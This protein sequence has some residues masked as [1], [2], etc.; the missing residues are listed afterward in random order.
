MDPFDP[1]TLD[2][3]NC[4]V[5]TFADMSS[6][7]KDALCKV[8]AK[9]LERDQALL[10]QHQKL[11][12]RVEN[13]DEGN[14]TE[15]ITTITDFIAQVDANGDG[16]VDGLAGLITVNN[17]LK[18]RVAKL[19]SSASITAERLDLL[20]QQQQTTRGETDRNTRDIAEL[21]SREDK[22]GVT[23]ERAT[24]IAADVACKAVLQPI[25]KAASDFA[26]AISSIA[27]GSE[28]HQAFLA[29]LN[30]SAT[31]AGETSTSSE[32]STMTTESRTEVAEENPAGD[33]LG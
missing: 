16:K 13:L 17:D 14:V 31:T 21:K 23:E 29:E 9:S 12:K 11:V 30:G 28:E 1:K 6:A 8:D 25:A 2:P 20:Q 22:V 10:T 15:I 33:V 7:L 19:E 27:C 24:E 5:P 26:A 3:E 32:S 4:P 18:E